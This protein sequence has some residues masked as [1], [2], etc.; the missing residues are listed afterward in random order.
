MENT[1][2]SW[3]ENTWNPM[4]GCI[5]VSDGC[6]YCYAEKVAEREKGS[7]A[8]PDGFKLTLKPHKLKDPF[9]WKDPTMI[10]VDS[11][12][13]LFISEAIF[14]FIDDIIGVIRDTPRHTYQVLTK[15]PSIM[16]KYFRTRKAPDNL[17]IGTSIENNKV[18]SSRI[19]ALCEI[20]CYIRF[21]S[22]EPLLEKLDHLNLR[23]INWVIVGGESGVHLLDKK[24]RDKRS[25][26][27]LTA[28]GKWIPRKD[29]ID[30]VRSIKSNCDAY[31]THFF[32][33]QW[34]GETPKSAGNLLDGKVYEEMPTK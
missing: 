5:K 25:L 2:I 22:V 34:G 33:K 19:E 32:F 7:K 18:A 3:T 21:L 27:T 4:S 16:S 30:W 26:A 24:I 10:F 28:D 11:M 9:K 23:G 14:P 1:K 6:K 17:W 12:S 29:R 20:D 8:Y 31:G 13:D 15:R